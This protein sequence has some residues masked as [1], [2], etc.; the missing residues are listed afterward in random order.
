MSIRVF[1]AVLLA[2]TIAS[3]AAETQP[4]TQ[5]SI[6][7]LKATVQTA[8]SD[9]DAAQTRAIEEFDRSPAGKLLVADLAARQSALEHARA[10][11]GTQQDRLDASAA[12][13]RARKQLDDARADALKK[14]ELVL[15]AQR[16]VAH[17]KASLAAAVVEEQSKA[18]AKQAAEDEKARNDP[19]R[20]AV[21][22]HQVLQGMTADQ[23][24][25]AMQFK[26]DPAKATWR[27]ERSISQP[28]DG[29]MI[30]TWHIG[31]TSRYQR[32]FTETRTVT[33]VEEGGV[34]VKVSQT[35]RSEMLDH[36]PE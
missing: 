28:G 13:N 18:D 33:V 21:R 11:S 9:L 16:K 15:D 12:F 34:V 10:T 1:F 8:R 31:Y 32:E 19:V 3:H 4:A 30:S 7:D 29:R 35:I 27:A 2:L 36:E 6:N 25:Q 17:A 22:K 24:K 14:S 23:V 20:I 5:P 26:N